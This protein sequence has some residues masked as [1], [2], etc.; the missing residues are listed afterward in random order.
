MLFLNVLIVDWMVEWIGISVPD[1][2]F[3]LVI[4]GAYAR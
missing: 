3:A 2:L 1:E 4:E